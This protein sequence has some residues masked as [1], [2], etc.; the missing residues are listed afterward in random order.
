MPK[1]LK[2]CKSMMVDIMDGKDFK[3]SEV[4]EFLTTLHTYMCR[5][6]SN[7]LTLAFKSIADNMETKAPITKTDFESLVE[8]V[9]TVLNSNKKV[10]L[11]K[12]NYIPWLHYLR[13]DEVIY[14]SGDCVLKGSKL[15]FPDKR[16]STVLAVDEISTL[17]AQVGLKNTVLVYGILLLITRR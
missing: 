5:G 14:S 1:T 6:Y 8:D 4:S 17:L 10:N 12:Y 11:T 3:A 2:E 16:A 7:S 13:N 9:F 15:N